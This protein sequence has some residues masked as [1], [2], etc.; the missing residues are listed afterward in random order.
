MKGEAL[1]DIPGERL[2]ASTMGVRPRDVKARPS[3]RDES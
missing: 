1:H 2:N 3:L